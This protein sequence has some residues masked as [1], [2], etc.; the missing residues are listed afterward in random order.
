MDLQLLAPFASKLTK[1]K[2]KT[3]RNEMW[4]NNLTSDGF[5]ALGARLMNLFFRFSSDRS[6]PLS[7]S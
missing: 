2:N 3:P 4:L 1:K 6:L 5:G 7:S